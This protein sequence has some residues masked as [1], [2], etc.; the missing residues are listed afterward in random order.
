MAA[1]ECASASTSGSDGDGEPGPLGLALKLPSLPLLIS[2]YHIRN[3]REA[4]LLLDL[5]SIAS[6]FDAL[7]RA[8]VPLAHASHCLQHAWD[9]LWLA[10]DATVV[11]AIP[12][13]AHEMSRLNWARARLTHLMDAQLRLLQ[14]RADS[15]RNFAELNS[16]VAEELRMHGV[17][18][19]AAAKER[20][21]EMER[22][23]ELR[24]R[25]FLEG[26]FD[27]DGEP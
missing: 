12:L 9:Q 22:G 4:E 20:L 16:A 27:V 10:Q 18:S 23:I 11:T 8:F 26:S 17:D 21:V 13:I 25:R 5:A 15:L 14:S 19:L 1:T 24:L 3:G 7:F 2:H 6:R